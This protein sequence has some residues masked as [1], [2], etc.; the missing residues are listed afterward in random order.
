M[1]L[2]F[3]SAGFQKILYQLEHRNDVAALL[4]ILLI[5]RQ[6]LGQHQNDGSQQTLCGIV[7]E[8]ILATATVIAVWV[9]DSLGQDL[10]VLFGLGTGCKILRVFPGDV[11]ITVD[12]CQ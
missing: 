6:E 7:E 5:G 10:G 8:S 2:V 1:A 12:Q 11:H 3:R 9:D 4:G